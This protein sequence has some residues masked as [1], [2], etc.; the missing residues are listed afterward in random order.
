MEIVNHVAEVTRLLFLILVLHK[1]KFKCS[2][3]ILRTLLRLRSCAGSINVPITPSSILINYFILLAWKSE[4]I[5]S[6]QSEFIDSCSWL[7]LGLPKR[8]Q[9]FD[10]LTQCTIHPQDSTMKLFSSCLYLYLFFFIIS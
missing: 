2:P 8:Q 6:R 10:I 5:L 3:V 4:T 7:L 1:L 9:C